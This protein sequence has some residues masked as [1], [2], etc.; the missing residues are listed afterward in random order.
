MHAGHNKVSNIVFSRVG[1]Y[2]LLL[3]LCLLYTPIR[4]NGHFLGVESCYTAGQSLAPG[5]SVQWTV[6]SPEPAGFAEASIAA[7]T[8]EWANEDQ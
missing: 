6:N 3:D 1:D 5:E 7:I 8:W 2:D 4:A